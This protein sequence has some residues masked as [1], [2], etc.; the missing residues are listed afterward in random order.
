MWSS[1]AS[2]ARLEI[3]ELVDDAQADEASTHRPS[4]SQ[5]VAMSCR[6]FAYRA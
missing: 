5:F 2:A 3:A 6:Y 1:G 4:S